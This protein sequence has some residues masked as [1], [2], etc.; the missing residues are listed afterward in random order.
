M[1]DADPHAVSDRQGSRCLQE[2]QDP[3][4]EDS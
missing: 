2:R 4:D 1:G 3:L